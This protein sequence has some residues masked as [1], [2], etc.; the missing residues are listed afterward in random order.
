MAKL[1]VIKPKV[2]LESLAKEYVALRNQKSLIETKMKELANIMKEYAESHG[3]KNDSGSYYCETPS[4]FVG[5]MAKK[6]ISFNQEKAVDFLRKHDL[7][8]AVK[9]TESVD[10]SVVEKYIAS[11]AISYADLESITTTK[12]SYAIDL[13][14]KE[15]V[16]EVQQTSIA[17][18]SRKGGKT[19]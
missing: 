13:K 7:Y 14:E 15:E 19:K 2:D 16:S 11:G 9:V 3:T 17:A 1:T 4:Y 8:D 10:E 12:V 18:K 6:S 5:K